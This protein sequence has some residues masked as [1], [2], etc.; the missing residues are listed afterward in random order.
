MIFFPTDRIVLLIDRR[1]PSDAILE[2]VERITRNR[3]IWGSFFCPFKNRKFF[4]PTAGLLTREDGWGAADW[5][6]ED[7][8]AYGMSKSYF[9]LGYG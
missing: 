7:D 2:R 5:I 6:S 1:L 9:S 8:L 3:A 4:L